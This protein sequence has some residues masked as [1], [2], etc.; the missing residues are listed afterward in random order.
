MFTVR[1]NLADIGRA[2]KANLGLMLVLGVVTALISMGV[3]FGLDEPSNTSLDPRIRD[4]LVMQLVDGALAIL[5]LFVLAPRILPALQ[6][7]VPWNRLPVVL[8]LSAVTH[9]ATAFGFAFF[10][11]PGI[12][13]SVIFFA[14]APF[15]LTRGVD[16][17]LTESIRLGWRQFWWVFGTLLMLLLVL[18]GVSML[19]FVPLYFLG[20][21]HP[22]FIAAAFLLAVV[23]VPA[24]A[25]A[26][27]VLAQNLEGGPDVVPSEVVDA[28]D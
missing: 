8:L 16:Q 15:A 13:L 1:G 7:A 9:V 25:V 24:A 27:L 12:I 5:P 2:W 28:F 20:L 23:T 4:S 18:I 17:A 19:A 11:I 22:I 6:R 14:A 3:R 21:D 10:I 26:Q